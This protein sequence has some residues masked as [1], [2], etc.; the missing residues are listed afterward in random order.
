MEVALVVRRN[1]F[2]LHGALFTAQTKTNS[3]T[4]NK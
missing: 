4:Y 2:R 3:G 1:L